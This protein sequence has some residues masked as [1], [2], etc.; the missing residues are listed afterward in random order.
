MG[1]GRGSNYSEPAWNTRNQ[2]T[3]TN[4]VKGGLRMFYFPIDH[5]WSFMQPTRDLTFL[6]GADSVQL[7]DDFMGMQGEVTLV[8]SGRISRP[9]KQSNEQYINDQFANFPDRT[10]QPEVCAI[11]WGMAMGVYKSQRANLYIY[12]KADQDYTIR[13]QYF[14]QPDTL[15]TSF[16]YAYGGTTHA[17][18]IKAAC[19]AIA[20]RDENNVQDGPQYAYFV[21]RMRASVSLDRH[22]KAQSMGYNGDRGYNRQRLRSGFGHW[23]QN[24]PVT[25]NQ[26]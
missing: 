16:P 1:F 9:I 22:N 13:L 10:G 18:T 15:S 3:I 14:L 19:K 24:N 17:E 25:Y 7:P 20:E 8:D 21:E 2:L 11:R 4:C 5:E 6:S 12:P 23:L 26:S